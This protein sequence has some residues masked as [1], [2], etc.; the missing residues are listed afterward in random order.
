MEL[1]VVDS[2]QQLSERA[3][4]AVAAE[5]KAKPA[6]VLGLATG[7]TPEGMYS[8]LVKLNREGQVD[9]SRVTTFNL[10]EY[11]GLAPGHEQ[12][13]CY[14]MHRHLFNLVNI[15]PEQVNIPGCDP[16]NVDQFCREYDQ[17]IAAAGGI[18]LQVLGIGGNGHIGFNEPGAYLRVHT[19]LVN[20]T[21]ETIA[22]NSRF[23]HAV[24]E[25]PKQAISM[26]LGSIMLAKKIILLA[27]G[28]AK[29]EA[30]ARTVCGLIDTG[31]PAS[32]L[33]LHRDV[34]IIADREAAALIACRSRRS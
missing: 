10:D 1:I 21:A 31:L 5:I 7:S 8:E 32:I 6:A 15:R 34:T 17:R 14:Y 19:H 4:A 30:I 12:S 20:L 13:Y 27:S 29:A 23:F 24:E 33:Q 26:G 2:Y 3:A 22:A 16:E 18:D 11:A 28:K 25:V 9:F